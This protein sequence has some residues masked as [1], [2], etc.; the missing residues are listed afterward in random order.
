MANPAK[1]PGR[2]LLK[3]MSTRTKWL[4][5]APF[6]LM[7]IGY[8]LCV[9]SGAAQAMHSGQPFKQWFI[10]GTYSLVLINGGISLFGQAVR[11]R[12]MMDIRQV[13]RRQLRKELKGRQKR[14]TSF[15]NRNEV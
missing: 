3:R 6:S 2:K 5:L 12:V 1:P 13:V 7:L 9:F 10:L 15:G 11:L 14:K 8:G 4:L